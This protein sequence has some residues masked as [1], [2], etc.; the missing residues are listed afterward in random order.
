M[1]CKGCYYEE[2]NSG[3]P[4]PLDNCL[5]KT[6]NAFRRYCQTIDPQKIAEHIVFYNDYRFLKKWEKQGVN[7]Y[8]VLLTLGEAL[9]NA[10][11]HKEGVEEMWTVNV[12]REDIIYDA[13][14]RLFVFTPKSRCVDEAMEMI[15]PK[16][17]LVGAF[18]LVKTK[19]GIVSEWASYVTYSEE[20][21]VSIWIAKKWMKGDDYHL[22]RY[23]IGGNDGKI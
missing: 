19:E 3:L 1:G 22:P 21:K 5:A 7:R 12:I 20:G 23:L 16:L 17:P 8:I 15:A 14:T 18:S 10:L 4:C 11:K 6:V 2:G 9:E 13:C